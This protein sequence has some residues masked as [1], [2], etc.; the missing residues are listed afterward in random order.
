MDFTI[1]YHFRKRDT[2]KVGKYRGIFKINFQQDGEQ[3]TLIV[4]YSKILEIEVIK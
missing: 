2:A 4:P 1:Q 3:K